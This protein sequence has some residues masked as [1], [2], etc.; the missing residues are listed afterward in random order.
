ME[1]FDYDNILLLPRQC[2]VESRSEC[3]ASVELGGRRFR[4]P[5][6]PANMKTVVNESICLWL[7]QHGYFY[8][9]HRFDIDNVKFVRDMHEQGAFASISLG[10][11]AP[12]YETVNTLA[13]SELVPEYITIDIAHGHAESVKNMIAH[14]K[15]K[16]PTAF[17]I[18]GNVG[19]PEAIID[20]EN[21]GADATKVGIG[22]GKVCITKLKTGFGTGGW[23]LSAL[24]W[25]ARVATK[26]IIA[27]GGIREHGDI[28]KSIRFGATFVMIGSMLAGHEESPGATV[29]VDG[30][31]YKEYYGSASDFNKGEYRHVE[32]KRIL[33]PVKG[34]L[35]DTLIEME[36]DVQS[37]ISYSGGKKL[38][39]IRKVNY[40]ILGGDNAGEHLLM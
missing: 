38:M 39:D 24:K 36:Q 1:I 10:V 22:P 5:V 31:L 20:L 40:V 35:A 32:G 18:A 16:L 7:A 30:R 21:W 13:A 12:D 9:M 34:Q 8:V 27:D 6:V 11:K 19:T 29:E 25:C 26:P 15:N 23:Q 2:R 37:S 33:E 14:I 3:D 17:V 28:A 4:L